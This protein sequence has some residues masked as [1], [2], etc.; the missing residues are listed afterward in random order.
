MRRLIAIVV[1]CVLAP[2]MA[3][4]VTADDSLT[5]LNP[6]WVAAIRNG[7]VWSGYSDCLAGYASTSEFRCA[8]EFD[9]G[10]MPGLVRITAATLKVTRTAGDCPANNCPLTLQAY[11]G[12]HQAEVSDVLAGDTIAT[13]TP[14]DNSPHSFDVKDEIANAYTTNHDYVGFSLWSAGNYGLYQYFDP[15]KIELDMSF[16]RAVDVTLK[17]VSADG[18]S[19]GSVVFTPGGVSCLSAC[20]FATTEGATVTLTA[21]PNPGSLLGTW[22][23]GPCSGDG[24]PTCTFVVPATNLDVGLLWVKAPADT[25]TPPGTT[26]T[27]SPSSS[28]GASTPPTAPP[29]SQT[30]PSVAASSELV[31][32]APSGALASDTPSAAQSAGASAAPGAT[33]PSSTGGGVPV[34][35]V[36]LL[37]VA[38]IVIGGGGFWVGNRRRPPAS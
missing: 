6:P 34:P 14:T 30:A 25:A 33:A 17:P 27:P 29:G 11:W 36:I 3:A 7:D 37:L 26:S 18:V 32:A 21:K 9:V 4:R 8:W 2:A 28:K 16:A 23:L 12:N 19:S 10:D 31:S 35:V 5:K 20:V 22:T 1:A 38:V 15:T 24:S 13:W